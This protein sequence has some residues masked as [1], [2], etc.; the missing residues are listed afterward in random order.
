MSDIPPDLFSQANLYEI[1]GDRPER[2]LLSID[3]H[4]KDD[5]PAKAT[6]RQIDLLLSE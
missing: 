5:D 4:Q 3:G 2:K 6:D 1:S